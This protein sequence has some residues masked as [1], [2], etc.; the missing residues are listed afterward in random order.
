M[1][2]LLISV[3]SSYENGPEVIETRAE[4]FGCSI[5]LNPVTQNPETGSSAYW[6]YYFYD[7]GETPIIEG[8]RKLLTQKDNSD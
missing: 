4:T 1:L 7:F 5:N 8:N 2:T 3:Y 6:K